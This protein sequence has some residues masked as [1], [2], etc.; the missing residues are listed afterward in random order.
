[1][2]SFQTL[3]NAIACSIVLATGGCSEEDV[4]FRDTITLTFSAEADGGP[5]EWNSKTYSTAAGDQITIDR[6]KLYVSDLQLINSATGEA[7]VEQDGYH[8]VS[9]NDQQNEYAI[10]LSGIRSDFIF[11]KVKF[12]IGVD[13]ERNS[14]IDNV[15]DLDPTND[16]AWDWNTGYKF[17]L[18]EGRFL[19]G[20]DLDERGLVLHIGLDRN[21]KGQSIA[22]PS[23]FNIPRSATLA[24]ELDALAPFSGKHEINLSDRS[25]YMVSEESDKIADNYAFGLV[26]L[27]SVD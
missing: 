5:L 1:M 26:K 23:P 14:S 9:L 8:L 20:D 4:N 7:F 12:A 17:F 18:M 16:M 13:P 19:P 2:K 6:M 3:F 15:G 24:F 21:Y 25:H 10:S 27:K 11:D 22:M